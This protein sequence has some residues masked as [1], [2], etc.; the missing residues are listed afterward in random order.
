MLVLHWIAVPTMMILLS[1]LLLWGMQRDPRDREEEMLREI[2]SDD[3]PGA[4]PNPTAVNERQ[5]SRLLEQRRMLSGLFGETLPDM[6][7]T[8]WKSG[9]ESAAFQATYHQDYYPAEPEMIRFC[10]FLEEDFFECIEAEKLPE[11]S[12]FLRAYSFFRLRTRGEDLVVESNFRGGRFRHELYR[13]DT[14]GRLRALFMGP[15]IEPSPAELLHWCP[16]RD[17]HGVLD[18]SMEAE[19]LLHLLD[20]FS[21][22]AEDR[23]PVL[24]AWR[25]HLL[26]RCGGEPAA[27]RRALALSLEFAPGNPLGQL[28]QAVANDGAPVRRWIRRAR[29]QV[30]LETENEPQGRFLIAQAL[31]AMRHESLARVFCEQL[32]LDFPQ[33]SGA[34]RLLRLID[35]KERGAQT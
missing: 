22:Q 31:H 26:L 15:D 25:A 11:G 12:R 16:Y 33:H 19:E 20:A 1:A 5:I 8:F 4:P 35:Q 9:E 34:S 17:A 21:G 24:Q 18:S 32:L 2:A 3:P 10:E 30:R 29:E 14:D 13:L 7:V 23:D 6:T 27:I 28:E